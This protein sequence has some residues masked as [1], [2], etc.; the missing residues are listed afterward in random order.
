MYDGN[1]YA[2]KEVDG[3]GGAHKSA[4]PRQEVAGRAEH[5]IRILS[6]LG[7]EASPSL[8]WLRFCRR[9]VPPDQ[10]LPALS[11]LSQSLFTQKSNSETDF[12]KTGMCWPPGRPRENI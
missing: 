2:K 6:K 4:A 10:H 3:R 11:R 5:V 7:G 8:R 12:Q 1:Q 9:P